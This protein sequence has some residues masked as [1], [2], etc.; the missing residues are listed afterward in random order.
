M[1]YLSNW[2]GR[3]SEAFDVHHLN[4]PS[5]FFHVFFPPRFLRPF[6][7]VAKI[8][9]FER[10]GAALLS[11]NF[12]LEIEGRKNPIG[13]VDTSREKK[14][15]KKGKK[16]IS[17]AATFSRRF[18]GWENFETISRLYE[19]FKSVES[20]GDIRFLFFSLPLSKLSSEAARHGRLSGRHLKFKS[21]PI[22]AR[23]KASK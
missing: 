13:N 11:Q 21:E 14:E 16:V 19:L 8:D 15:K 9:G 23:C 2:G 6:A 22:P 1:F 3:G 20:S 17:C 12:P 18:F 4:H 5:S 10:L 7:R